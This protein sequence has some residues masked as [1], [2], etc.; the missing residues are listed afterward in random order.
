MKIDLTKAKLS[1]NYAEMGAVEKVH[2]VIPVDKP[3]KTAFFRVHP[4][5]VFTFETFLINYERSN[6]MIYPEVAAQFPELTKA[7][8]LVLAVTRDGNPYLWPLRLPTEDGRRDNWATSAIE[9]SELAKSDWMRMSANMSAGSY[10]AHRAKGIEHQPAWPN[11]DMEELIQKAFRDFFIPNLE[12]P[13]ARELLG[14]NTS[15]TTAL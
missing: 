15:E 13:V 3:P 11:M 7:V 4:D 5:E 12:H 6:F 10:S 14:D 2:A 1:Q 8:R 9:I